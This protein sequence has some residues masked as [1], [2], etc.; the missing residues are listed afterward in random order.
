M[1]EP[2]RTHLTKRTKFRHNLARRLLPTALLNC[3]EVVI[4]PTRNVLKLVEMHIM[5]RLLC[6]K[7]TRSVHHRT[8]C[9]ILIPLI[10]MTTRRGRNICKDI[11]QA[12]DGSDMI[13]IRLIQHHTLSLDGKL[14]DIKFLRAAG[15]QVALQVFHCR[16]SSGIPPRIL[17][18]TSLEASQR[19]SLL[20]D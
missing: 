2:G 10:L 6:T 9:P 16:H 13:F 12:K 5:C 14:S 7:C 1:I 4:I 19:P 8:R 15:R 3:E 18:M 11:L 17:Q 20:L